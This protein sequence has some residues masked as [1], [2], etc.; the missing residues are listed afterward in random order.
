MAI[1]TLKHKHLV[2]DQKKLERAKKILNAKTDTEVLD[3]A[4]DIVVTE[5]ELDAVLRKVGGKGRIQKIFH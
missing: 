2:L 1:S 3:R 4:L 5:S